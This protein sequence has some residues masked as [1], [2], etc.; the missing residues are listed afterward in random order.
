MFVNFLAWVTAKADLQLESG[1]GLRASHHSREAHAKTRLSQNQGRRA[2]NRHINIYLKR[3]YNAWRWA[4]CQVG[5]VGFSCRPTG[6]SSLRLTAGFHIWP[7]LSAIA[8]SSEARKAKGFCGPASGR[9]NRSDDSSSILRQSDN[10]HIVVVFLIRRLMQ[11]SVCSR[12][13]A[14]DVFQLWMHR[15]MGVLPLLSDRLIN[16]LGELHDS[17]ETRF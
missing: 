6:S 5:G 10:R 11:Q 15:A 2:M 16:S 13:L 17:V 9:S 1:L 3:N 4:S 8:R 7:A 14:V 12:L